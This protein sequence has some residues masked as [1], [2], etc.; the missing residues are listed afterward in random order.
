M[1]IIME[2]SLEVRG[3]KE[4][5]NGV[6]RRMHGMGL[7]KRIALEETSHPHLSLHYIQMETTYHIL[8][9]LSKNLRL[10]T[11]TIL[12]VIISVRTSVRMQPIPHLMLVLN[13]LP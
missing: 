6:Q 3:Q 11:T 10:T 12:V 13:L 9:M 7:L 1:N 5:V 4:R 8:I 2:T